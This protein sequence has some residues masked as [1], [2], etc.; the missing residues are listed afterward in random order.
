MHIAQ[1]DC[2]HLL[3]L[4]LVRITPAFRG[5]QQQ[6]QRRCCGSP[7]TRCWATRLGLPHFS[8]HVQI[9]L[10]ALQSRS[11]KS[12]MPGRRKPP[13]AESPGYQADA[14][15]A[16]R[17]EG[18]RYGAQRLPATETSDQRGNPLCIPPHGGD[19]TSTSTPQEQPCPSSFQP[20][21]IRS[22]ESGPDSH[23]YG[24][25]F[26]PSG[27]TWTWVDSL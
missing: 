24:E 18:D 6:A 25:R 8:N 5:P 9:G 27:V 26:T 12:R 22:A 2:G 21:M 16:H 7:A 1:E 15:S 23:L 11:T 17:S 10:V 14:N 3:S 4:A 20:A 19:R 13:I